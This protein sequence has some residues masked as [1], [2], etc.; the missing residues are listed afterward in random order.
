[1]QTTPDMNIP[2]EYL[3]DDWFEEYPVV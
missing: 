3:T 1:M 2:Q